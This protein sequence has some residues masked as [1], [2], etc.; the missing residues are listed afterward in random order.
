[1]IKC[2]RVLLKCSMIIS[3]GWMAGVARLGKEA[4]I[5]K[6]QSLCQSGVLFICCSTLSAGYCSMGC[7]NHDDEEIQGS[8]DEEFT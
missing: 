8:E 3:H 2:A 4:Q 6:P 1:M 5:G 7:Q